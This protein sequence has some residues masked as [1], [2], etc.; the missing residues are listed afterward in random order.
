MSEKKSNRRVQA[1]MVASSIVHL[2]ASIRTKITTE[3]M[4]NLDKIMI[5]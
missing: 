3:H 2:R 5:N 4:K 1:L